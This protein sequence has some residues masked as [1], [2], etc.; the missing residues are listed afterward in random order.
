MYS[1]VQLICLFVLICQPP[2]HWCCMTSTVSGA[3]QNALVSVVCLPIWQGA[4]EN[5]SKD[6]QNHSQP[7]VGQIVPLES[8]CPQAGRAKL[9]LPVVI[10]HVKLLFK[11]TRARRHF[12]CNS[13]HER[14]CL[15][16]GSLNSV[17]YAVLCMKILYSSPER[18]WGR[19][20]YLFPSK[21]GGEDLS[22]TACGTNANLHA[23]L[24]REL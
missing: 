1:R 19:F 2:G 9:G 3:F 10:F 14:Y 5:K 13:L 12:S 24:F 16:T 20:I 21:A 22:T 6:W 7:F 11:D 4:A 8:T 18:C 23:S 17:W 15:W